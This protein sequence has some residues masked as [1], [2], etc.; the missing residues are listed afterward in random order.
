MFDNDK[1][2][3][4]VVANK[5]NDLGILPL[6]SRK[7]TLRRKLGLMTT[8][9]VHRTAAEAATNHENDQVNGTEVATNA[10]VNVPTVLVVG[11]G[12]GVGSIQAVVEELYSELSGHSKRGKVRGRKHRRSSRA[13]GGQA[14]K[15]QAVVAAA[16]ASAAAPN[17]QHQYRDMDAQIVVVCGRNDAVR[18][19]LEKKFQATLLGHGGKQPACTKP[20]SRREACGDRHRRKSA[21]PTMARRMRSNILRSVSQHCQGTRHPMMI[22]AVQSST[23]WVSI[24]MPSLWRKV[25]QR[26]AHHHP[27]RWQLPLFASCLGHYCLRLQSEPT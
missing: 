5:H 27:S 16:E 11:G 15:N 18:R 25:C 12:D 3:A 2:G 23:L 17:E 1:D 24:I 7:L 21:N 6:E 10:E 22:R 20:P 13:S 26:Y 8:T 19:R 14:E 9:T 4:F